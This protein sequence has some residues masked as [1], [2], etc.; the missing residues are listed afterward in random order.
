MQVPPTSTPAGSVQSTTASKVG[1]ASEVKTPFDR[2]LDK[3]VSDQ[4]GSAESE[5]GKKTDSVPGK[6]R[7]QCDS[8]GEC[9]ARESAADIV[10]NR[11]VAQAE[12]DYSVRAA[13]NL[14]E[15]ASP[16]M[17][18]EPPTPEVEDQE[19][20]LARSEDLLTL[21]GST[22]HV[23][24]PPVHS[25]PKPTEEAS[26]DTSL[27]DVS[28][29]ST[30]LP[31]VPVRLIDGAAGP[32][33]AERPHKEP[34]TQVL[35]GATEPS[36]ED[37]SATE[38]VSGKSLISPAVEAHPRLNVSAGSLESVP[39]ARLRVH[40]ASQPQPNLAVSA[41]PISPLATSPAGPSDWLTARAS[42]KL[43]PR[44]GTTAWE[45]ALGQKV[46]WMISDQQHTASLRL[47]PPEL[48]PLQ[49]VLTI[50]NNQANAAFFATEPEVRRAIEAAMPR[51]REMMDA[52]GI[53]LGD[54]TVGAGTSSDDDASPGA[55]HLSENG[56]RA[57]LD[58]AR[59]VPAN[60]T[61]VRSVS[62]GL[63]DTFA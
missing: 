37:S 59:S 10:D 40:T 26:L 5:V 60:W 17:S 28:D 12:R 29:C 8:S 9:R 54:A 7:K 21:I 56:P 16:I 4:K 49:V 47:D 57:G 41:V 35:E 20:P 24:Q 62:R 1:D 3:E 31:D 55:K 52:A 11:P 19:S 34:A 15:A 42:D 39:A 38:M 25:V 43:Q 27:P 61:E 33:F 14:V 32:G 46:C 6:R 2:V 45:A 58:E 53:Q 48:G 23:S 13:A 30:R 51:L 44:V 36:R 63:V 22:V 50:D 18:P